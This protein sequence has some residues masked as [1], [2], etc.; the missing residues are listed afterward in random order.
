VGCRAS[1]STRQA[2]GRDGPVDFA[3]L[4]PYAIADALER[5]LDDPDLRAR[6]AEQGAALRTERSW[7]HAAEQVEAGLRAAIDFTRREEG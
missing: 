1:S 7:D 4:D 2:F 5:L 3:A 6:R